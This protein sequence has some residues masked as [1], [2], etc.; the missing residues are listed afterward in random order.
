MKAAVTNCKYYDFIFIFH[1]HK[2][3]PKA[4]PKHRQIQ[5]LCDNKLGVAYIPGA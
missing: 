4:F 2:M 1:M 3:F 5:R